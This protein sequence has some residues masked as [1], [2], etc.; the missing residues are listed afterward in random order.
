MMEGMSVSDNLLP[1]SPVVSEGR[2]MLMKDASATTGHNNRVRSC[3]HSHV[4]AVTPTHTFAHARA[5]AYYNVRE[6][7]Q[8]YM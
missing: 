8:S 4:H 7:I 2:P 1:N 6:Y 5:L 3:I